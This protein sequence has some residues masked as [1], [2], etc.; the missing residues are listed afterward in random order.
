MKTSICDPCLAHNLLQPVHAPSKSSSNLV[1]WKST[2]LTTKLWNFKERTLPATLTPNSSASRSPRKAASKSVEQLL[3][4]ERLFTGPIFEVH[5]DTVIEPGGVQVTR[6][7]VI[8]SKS[9]VVMPIFPDGRILLIRQYR[10]AP[11]RFMW[12][13][14][15]GR[16]DEGE[17]PLPAARR[18]LLEETGYSAKRFYKLLEFFPSPGFLSESMIIYAAEGLTA[19]DA[20][21]E[22]DER[23]TPRI[24]TLN[25]AKKWIRRGK[26]CDAKTI[27]GILYYASLKR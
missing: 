26:I 14:V 8:H 13:L 6:D 1:Q 25:E 16:V 19:G 15:A 24:V 4:S 18:E 9:V 11:V 2:N 17:Q 5:R 22:E 3:N 20:Q 27:A 12:E 7:L 10:H 23:I 21:P